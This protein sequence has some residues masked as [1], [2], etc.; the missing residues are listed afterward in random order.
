[1]NR[2]ARHFFVES[3][4]LAAPGLEG[5]AQSKAILSGTQALQEQ[6]LKAYQPGLLPPN[7]R[8]RASQAV[9]LAFRVAEEAMS[10]SSLDFEHLAGVFASADADT[11]ILDRIC[12]ALAEP[13]RV[14]SPTDFHNSVHNAAPG[15][16]HIATRSRAPSS[17]IAAGDAIFAAGLLEA[18]AQ[19][20]CEERDCLLVAYDVRPPPLIAAH[21]RIEIPSGVAMVLTQ[22]ASA[23]ALAQVHIDVSQGDD[24]SRMQDASLEAMR[25][26]GTALRALPLLQAIAC[27]QVASVVLAGVGRQR[28]R[29]EVAPC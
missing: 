1:M 2:S 23:T 27:R 20:F 17:S 24:E 11:H 16:W 14:V 22:Q 21:R 29:L 26:K 19:M 7:E 28:V 25:L 15:Y 13:Q 18:S 4:G 8:R 12:R 6:E 5:W 10:G 3:I 9:R